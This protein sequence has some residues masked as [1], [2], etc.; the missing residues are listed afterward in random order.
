M[1][2]FGYGSYIPTRL[3]HPE[4]YLAN[5]TYYYDTPENATN[6]ASTCVDRRP[7]EALLEPRFRGNS[8]CVD[9]SLRTP[10]ALDDDIA[11]YLRSFYVTDGYK[12]GD[13]S[14]AT[15]AFTAAVYLAT[16]A[17][18]TTG[19]ADWGSRSVYFDAGADTTIPAMSLAA[20]I[21][22]S[23]LLGIYL[24]CLFAL[25]LYSARNYRWTGRLDAFA[26]MRIGAEMHEKVPLEVGFEVS[27]IR[28]LD[29]TPGVIGDATGGEGEVGVLGIGCGTPLHGARRYKSY[30]AD[31]VEEA[32]QVARDERLNRRNDRAKLAHESREV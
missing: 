17:W 29:E 5:T 14:R 7:F 31:A 1:A 30:K 21:G 18:F 24:A 19:R 20:M 3:A 11:R 16:E 15:N 26:M 2:L 22:L 28:V 9:D 13:T 12:L 23:A 4:A 32:R 8:E 10:A 27:A 6:H 25:S